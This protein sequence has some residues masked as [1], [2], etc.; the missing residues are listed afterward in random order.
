MI[1]DHFEQPNHAGKYS[2]EQIGAQ[3]KTEP[4]ELA[5]S[6]IVLIGIED[7]NYPTACNQ[8]RNELYSLYQPSKPL[9]LFDIGNFSLLEHELFSYDQL[10]DCLAELI[11]KNC[12]P[13]LFGS[14]RKVLYAM[15]K[16]FQL[17]KKY[18]NAGLITKAFQFV[19]EDRET[20]TDQ[21]VLLKICRQVNS[22]LFNFI[23]LGYQTYL[24]N[25]QSLT[26]QKELSFDE[27]RLGQI[28]DDS[29]E[30]EPLLRDIDLLGVSMDALKFSETANQTQCEP[31]GL[32]AEELAQL[33]RYAGMSD[34][35]QIISF[36][37][38]EDEKEDFT[39]A[40][41]IA[42]SIWCFLEG[43]LQRKREWPDI[44]DRKYVKY[45]V[46][47]D[48]MDLDLLFL[49]SEISGRWWIQM[50]KDKATLQRSFYIPCSYQDYQV[51]LNG[52]IPVRW[53]KGFQKLG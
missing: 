18:I 53:L 5:N 11:E 35:L 8:I 45:T 28:R 9:K 25:P 1:F 24:V 14:S 20:P 31:N 2:D 29:K 50:P 22:Y 15:H 34:K 48:E 4:N 49:K 26:I 13:V 47:N 7:A 6:S 19:E 32:Y 16:A 43:F 3:I 30:T 42:Q 12:L 38:F 51:A 23:Q 37:E 27:M 21:N 17:N 40:K 10:A 33:M 36:F 39:A 41:L 52:D 46:H 44:D